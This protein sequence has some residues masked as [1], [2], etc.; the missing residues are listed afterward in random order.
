MPAATNLVIKKADGVTDQTLVLVK[1]AAGDNAPAMWRLEAG[2]ALPAAMPTVTLRS[3][4]NGPSTARRTE[5]EVVYPYSVLSTADQS[6][7]VV[8]KIVIKGNSVLVP[9]NVPQSI[10]N[11]ATA[12]FQG[13]VASAAVRD[14]LRSGYA[15]T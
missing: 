12:L 9:L 11:E 6:I 3:R 15:P 10:V 1:A 4:S 5:I 13:F 7:R 14:T 8:S 2:F